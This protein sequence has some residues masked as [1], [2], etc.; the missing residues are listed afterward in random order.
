MVEIFLEVFGDML[1]TQHLFDERRR[2]NELPSPNELKRK[3]LL[4]GKIKLNKKVRA[5]ARG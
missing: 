2:A 5:I 3:I 4:K 1:V